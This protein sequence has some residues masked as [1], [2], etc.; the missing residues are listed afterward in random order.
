M[1]IV[2]STPQFFPS[3]FGGGQSYTQRLLREL[4]FRGHSVTILGEELWE[5][6]DG[7]Y[8]WSR[9]QSSDGSVVTFAL[10]PKF[11]TNAEQYS[12]FGPTIHA[13]LEEVLRDCRP[14]I[15]HIN[16]IKPALVNT[17]RELKLPHV[18]SVHHSGI[19]CPAGNLLKPNLKVCIGSVNAHDCVPCANYWR[20]PKWYT[21]GVIGKIPRGLYRKVGERLNSRKNLSYIERGLIHPFLIDESIKIK[22]MILERGQ[23]FITPSLAMKEL[24]ARNGCD[25]CKITLAHHGV[26]AMGAQPFQP[27]K[28]RP[29]RFGY[30]GRIDRLKGLHIALK[31]M[32]LLPAGSSELHIF[33]GAQTPWDE[34]Y[35]ADCLNVYKKKLKVHAHGVLAQGEISKAYEN[36]DVV[37]VPSILPEA[38]GLVIAEAFSA[39]RPV[40]VSNSWALP[41][42]VADGVDG[43]VVTRNDP[44]K[45]AEAMEKFLQNPNLVLE[46]SHR[47]PTVKTIQQ[48]VDEIEKIYHQLISLKN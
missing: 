20:R 40:I 2:V 15:V 5:K 28:G 37:V 17:C 18:A 39:G 48:Y 4:H 33:G 32:S 46:M 8:R 38:F 42:M 43:F 16:G 24:L 34:K 45:L 30:V 44:G 13:V 47:I 7:K 26:I 36:V 23:H 31:A 35:F 41:E 14:D 1:N 10:N 3:R 25:L 27:F 11:L 9:N 19:I 21:G 29:L 22:R 12:K 6:G